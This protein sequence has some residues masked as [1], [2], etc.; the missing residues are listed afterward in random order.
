[1]AGTNPD[2]RDFRLETLGRSGKASL[3]DQVEVVY[4]LSFCSCK[5]V[6]GVFRR[7]SR[8]PAPTQGA[9]KFTTQVRVVPD[10]LSFQIRAQSLLK[11]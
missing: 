6:D 2:A 10:T 3:A 9:F 5:G 4:R 11:Q 8:F 1:V 7:N